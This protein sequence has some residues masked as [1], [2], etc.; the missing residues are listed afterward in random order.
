MR[1]WNLTGQIHG[2]EAALIRWA[3]R[4]HFPPG[5][6]EYLRRVIVSGRTRQ[7]IEH[8][9][10]EVRPGTL[11]SRARRAGLVSP[12]A[13]QFLVRDIH[14]AHLLGERRLTALEASVLLNFSEG[15]SLARYVHN[16]HQ[17]TLE[18]FRRYSVAAARARFCLRLAPEHIGWD[19]FRPFGADH[20]I[21][22]EAVRY[23]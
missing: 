4:S 14:L 8:V 19:T 9:F 7:N 20:P 17:V 18:E 5:T 1:D 2:I 10:P 22:L 3:L 6:A 16:V 21:G 11:K 12:R 13:L 23:G 15:G